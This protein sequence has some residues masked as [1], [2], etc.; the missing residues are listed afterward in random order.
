VPDATNT[1]DLR[2][3][4]RWLVVPPAIGC[5][6]LGPALARMRQAL[7]A[8]TLAVLGDAPGPV[9]IAACVDEWVPDRA[10][11]RFA[12]DRLPALV[13]RWAALWFD[14]AVIFTDE[15]DTAFEA[16]YLAYLAGI[17]V[18]AGLACEFGGGVL[19]PAIAP[20]PAGTRGPTRHLFLLEALGL[21]AAP[22]GAGDP[23]RFSCDHSAS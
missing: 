18:R 1:T 16:A 4:R 15:G 14:A 23:L 6:D 11:A 21:H 10:L 12:V 17:R 7:P 2:A 13:E 9:T 5:R 22:A 19:A 3:L 20:P 8:A